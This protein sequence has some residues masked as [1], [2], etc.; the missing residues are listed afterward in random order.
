MS[1]LRSV[2][3]NGIEFAY[4]EEGEGPLILLLHGFPDTAKTWDAIRGPLAARGFRVVSPYM[5]GYSPT[6][7]PADAPD[8]RVLGE[9]VLALIA[10]LGEESAIVVGHDWGAVASYAAASLKP[11]MIQHLFVCAVPHPMAQKPSLAL[12]W[13]ARHFLALNLP[14]AAGRL[15]R[16]GFSYLDTLCRRWSPTWDFTDGDLEDVKRSLSAP[17]S[18]EAAVSYYWMLRS[19][20]PDLLFATTIDVPTTAIAGGDEP[21]IGLKMF[22]AARR[23]FGKEYEVVE[24]PGGHFAHRESPS[25][26]AAVVSARLPQV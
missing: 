8:A 7:V 15:R 2:D 22:E 3:A 14:G 23:C 19:G 13:Y 10:A 5:R 4:Y 16:G 12:L 1:E 9:D 24:I 25:E 26:F 18:A 20:K 11:E 21:V 17:G 6:Q